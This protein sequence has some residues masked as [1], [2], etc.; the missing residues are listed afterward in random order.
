MPFYRFFFGGEFHKKKKMVPTYPKLSN[1]EDLV[2]VPKGDWLF[3][4]RS[5]RGK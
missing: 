5:L 2:E 3:F 4:P 1:L